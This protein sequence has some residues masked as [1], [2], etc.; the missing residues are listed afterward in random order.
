MAFATKHNFTIAR[1]DDR[2]L[3]YTVKNQAI[4]PG[5]VDITA[6][7][8]IW[9]LSAQDASVSEPQPQ[10]G[11]L[12]TK[13]VGTGVTITDGPA[14]EVEVDFDSADTVGLRAPL[15]YYHE[16]Q[17]TLVGAVTT[18]VYGNIT[19]KRDVASPGP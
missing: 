9:I 18:L 14:G 12:V 19:V 3:T 10:G 5:P 13:A 15:D 6:A 2:T 7:T 17:M 11:A 4:P 16:L 1:G 8:F